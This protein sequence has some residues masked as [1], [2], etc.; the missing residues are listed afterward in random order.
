[1]LPEFVKFLNTKKNFQK[2]VDGLLSLVEEGNADDLETAAQRLLVVL[3]SRFSDPL[4]WSRGLEFFV[5]LDFR[6]SNEKTQRCIQIAMEEVDDEA[7]E[8]VAKAKQQRKME[9]QR[10]HNQ[11]VFAD[12]FTPITRGELLSAFNLLELD[13]AADARPAMSREARAALPVVK[14]EKPELC[15]VCQDDIPEGGIAKK[16]PCGHLFHD[17]CL[18]TW[19]EKANS[20]PMCRGSELPS[21]KIY[22]TDDERR[23]F[24]AD[25]SNLYA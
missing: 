24:Q 22:T 14:A 5:A 8:A 7:R 3:Q 17:E 6:R 16:M 20:C 1:M 11:G 9:E 15:P 2:G 25:S 12:R 10:K 23:A 13:A 4:Y 19:L 21:E 18:M